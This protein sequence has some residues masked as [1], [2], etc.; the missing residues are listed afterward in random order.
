LGL[1]TVLASSSACLVPVLDTSGDGDTGGSETV[2][3][4][5]LLLTTTDFATGALV[6]LNT[7]NYEIRERALASTD[8][9]PFAHGDR[10][11][12]VN[13]YGFDYV[14]VYAPDQGWARLNQIPISTP[15]VASTNP[16]EIAVA[17]SGDAYL[18]LYGASELL[19]LDVNQPGTD[20]IV[21]RIDT[22]IFADDDGIAEASLAIAGAEELTLAIQ[23]LD[24]TDGFS[25]VD[26]DLL[27]F[28][29]YSTHAF[30]DV[31]PDAEGVQGLKLPGSFPRQWRPDPSDSNVVYLLNTGVLRVELDSHTVSWAVSESLFDEAG[32]GMRLQAQSFALDETG[33]GVFVAA[34]DEAFT[35]VSIY[36]APLDGSAAPVQLV[37]GLNSVERTLEVVGESIWFASTSIGE[38]GLFRFGLD[39]AELMGPLDTGLSPYSIRSY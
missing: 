5:T 20:A 26:D 2:G 22:S 10:V 34:Y 25:P 11:F 38:E 6:T 19:V 14:D 8:A 18:S 13:R 4:Q 39:G 35:S 30:F 17:P 15:G 21:E 37:T 32:I 27:V 7:E 29:D 3:G 12:V 23:R 33:E 28:L 1:V 31:D 36:E 24:R 16:Q 9:I